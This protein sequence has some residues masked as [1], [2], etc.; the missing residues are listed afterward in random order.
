MNLT[1]AG[2]R[3]RWTQE[4]YQRMSQLGWF[5]G[6]KVQW[7][8]G[9][10]LVHEGP[11]GPLPR[12]W[13]R[14]EYVRMLDLGWLEGRRAELIGGEVLDMPAQFDLHLGGITLVA[15]ALRA[16][17]G[18]GFW[19]RVQG[20]L[21]LSPHGVPDPDVAVTPGGPRGT[22]RT[23]ATG[24]LL[25]VEVSDSTLGEDRSHKGSLYA[26]GGIADYWVLNLV[27]RQLEV[28]RG[29]VADTSQPFGFRYGSRVILDPPDRVSP[30]AL[31]QAQIL[32]ADLLP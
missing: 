25:V 21:D 8:A 10:I 19:V 6:Q 17:F 5:D 15:D 30:L 3:H 24:A 18:Q 23:I 12:R 9:D 32:V 13:S 1:A 26:A 29:P 11:G 27:Q 22:L 4:E 31:P 14:D 16:A 28:Y 2:R 20:S 7:V